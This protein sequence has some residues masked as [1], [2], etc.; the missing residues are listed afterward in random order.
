MFM[1][2]GFARL[3]AR[4]GATLLA[5]C[6]LLA[7][8]STPSGADDLGLPFA[9]CALTLA[10]ALVAWARPAH[11][12]ERA[13]AALGLLGIGLI[14]LQESAGGASAHGSALLYLLPVLYAACFLPRVLA[15]LEVLLCA[16]IHGALV[17]G[18]FSAGQAATSALVLLSAAATVGVLR[19]KLWRALDELAKLASHD[20]LTGVLNRR[21]FD[22]RMRIEAT[23]HV[24]TGEAVALLLVDIDRFKD[25]NDRHGHVVGDRVLRR[26]AG[27]LCSSVRA[28]DAVARLGGEEFAVLLPSTTAEQGL[29]LAERLLVRVACWHSQTG[30]A[31]T[32]SIGVADSGSAGLSSEQ[33]IEAA[34][35]ALYEAKRA[36]RNRAA[37][38][39]EV[40]PISTAARAGGL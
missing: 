27:D 24:R 18:S 20:G 29:V 1:L 35:R 25:V 7:A 39:Q 9:A 32:I 30:P 26:V 3:R 22:E 11:F 23:R 38:A 31:V 15:V 34:D 6:A 12:G 40:L 37:L 16:S 14:A 5:T 17:S 2:D 36:G 21:G 28:L 8:A 10:L 4:V 33:L 19:D 13:A